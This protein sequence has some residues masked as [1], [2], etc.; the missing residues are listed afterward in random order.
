MIKL[1][2]KFI[3]SILE[4][5]DEDIEDIKNIIFLKA[6]KTGEIKIIES[7]IKKGY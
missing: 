6:A 4:K 5:K 3:E 2:E 1:F 7:F